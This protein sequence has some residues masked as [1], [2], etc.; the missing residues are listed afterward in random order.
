MAPFTN[1]GDTDSSLVCVCKTEIRKVYSTLLTL[2]Y[3]IYAIR[4]ANIQYKYFIMINY[5]YFLNL[6]LFTLHDKIFKKGVWPGKMYKLQAYHLYH[7]WY[8]LHW[9]RDIHWGYILYKKV[10]NI[11]FSLFSVQK[12]LMLQHQQQ[13]PRPQ[14]QEVS[15]LQYW[16]VIYSYSSMMCRPQ[17]HSD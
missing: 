6:F 14:L 4:G 3:I 16:T 13:R 1:T 15:V 11:N 8:M 17:L 5:F 12:C 2:T 10:K 7:H 9:M